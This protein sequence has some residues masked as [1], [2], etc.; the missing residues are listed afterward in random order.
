M[1]KQYQPHTLEEREACDQAILFILGMIEERINNNHEELKDMEK[2]K[3]SQNS[4]GFGYVLG[5]F[6]ELV[7]LKSEIDEIRH[8]D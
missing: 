4:V 6:D 8:N 2:E 5:A 1:N 3:I 7:S